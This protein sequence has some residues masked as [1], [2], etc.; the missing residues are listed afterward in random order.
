VKAN[1]ATAPV[2]DKALVIGEIPFRVGKR[3]VRPPY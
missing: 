2:T 1:S 3:K